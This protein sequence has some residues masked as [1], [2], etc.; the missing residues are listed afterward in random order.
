MC[1]RDRAWGW[2]WPPGLP[3]PRCWRWCCPRHGSSWRYAWCGGRKSWHREGGTCRA[4]WCVVGWGG[5]PGGGDLAG[6]RSHPQERRDPDP[7][8]PLARAAR[9]APSPPRPPRDRGA[10]EGLWAALVDSDASVNLLNAAVGR[11]DLH[12]IVTGEANECRRVG[13]RVAWRRAGRIVDDDGPLAGRGCVVV[14]GLRC[15]GT[16]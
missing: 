12:G 8:A 5:G 14:A 1:I 10:L 16:R 7:A 11:A 13:R 4:G 9:H 6:L 3:V 2:R 15:A